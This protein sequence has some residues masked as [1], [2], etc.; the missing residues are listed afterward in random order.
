MRLVTQLGINLPQA[1]S[2]A[3][4]SNGPSLLTALEEQLGLKLASNA[5]RSV[6]V[7]DSAELPAPD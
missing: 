3:R 7:V 2:N 6:L 4:P 5:G 1:P